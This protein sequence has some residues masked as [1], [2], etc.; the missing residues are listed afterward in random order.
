MT[1]RPIKRKNT[2]SKTRTVMPCSCQSNIQGLKAQNIATALASR[3]RPNIPFLNIGKKVKNY[4]ISRYPFSR[5]M[6]SP[7][8]TEYPTAEGLV[9]A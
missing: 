8:S 3:K 5:V 7:L 1:G 4:S 2:A 9:S 6:A